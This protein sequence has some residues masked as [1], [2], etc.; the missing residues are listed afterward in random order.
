MFLNNMIPAI[1]NVQ[2]TLIEGTALNNTSIRASEIKLHT[3]SPLKMPNL[4][5][6]LVYIYRGEIQLS[7]NQIHIIV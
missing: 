3:P 7:F 2:N 6:E 4:L 1:C 5:P